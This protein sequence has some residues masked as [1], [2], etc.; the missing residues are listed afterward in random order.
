MEFGERLREIRLSM[1][2]NMPEFAALLGT[3]KQNIHRYEK[4]DTSPTLRVA[5][6]YAD[7]LGVTVLYLLG[8]E[9]EEN[10]PAVS[11]ETVE[12]LSVLRD[13]ERA[14]LQ[15][16]KDMTPDQVLAMAEFAKS[17]RSTYRD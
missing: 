4:G 1:G 8:S 7:K 6:E 9:D 12:A 15:V 5:K 13:E 2:L 11:S 3:S 10:G 14:L 16:T 17:L